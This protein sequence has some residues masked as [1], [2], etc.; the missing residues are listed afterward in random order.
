MDTSRPNTDSS[1][2]AYITLLEWMSKHGGHIHESVQIA[3]DERRG[4]H[5]QVKADCRDGLPSNTNVIKTPLAAT[6]SY[7]N[8]IEHRSAATEDEK[9]PVSFSAHGLHFPRSFV[10]AAGPDETAIFF[11]I[12]QYLRGS[13]GFWYPYICT[14]PQPGDLTTPLY[15]EG[16]DLR[17]LEGT[18]LAPAREQKESLL[19][20]KYQS[21]FEELRNSGFG[22]AEKYTW[23][24]YLWASTIFVSRAFSAKVLAG[25]IPH[26]ELPEENVSVL[27]PFI[28]VLNHRPLAK[29]EWRAGERDVLFVVLEH[30]AAGEEVANNYGPRNN[31][32]LMMNYGFCLQNNPCDYRT[33]SL[34]APPGSPL[35]DAKKAQLE[36]FPSREKDDHYYVFNI[37]YPLLAPDTSMEHSIFSPALLNAVSVLAANSRELETLEVSEHEI[38]LTQVYARTRPIL[39]ALGQVIIELITHIVRLKAS[40]DG[41]DNP[42]NLKQTHANIYRNSQIMLSQTALVIAAWTLNRARQHN[43]GSSWEETKQLLA[44]HMARVPAGLFPEEV[45]SR[46]QFRILERPSLVTNNGELFTPGDLSE[47]FAAGMQKPCKA[48]IEAATTAGWEGQLGP[49]PF[50]F[51][52]FLCLV[53]GIHRADTGASVL[54]PR[55]KTWVSFLLEKYESLPPSSEELLSLPDPE[56]E[57]LLTGLDEHIER[58][59]SDRKWVSLLSD[60]EAYAGDWRS[61]DW[62]LSPNSLRWAWMVV[63]EETVQIP[64]DPLGLLVAAE[65]GGSVQLATESYLYVAGEV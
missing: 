48:F 19:K 16:A 32:Q 7:F 50:V 46:I 14:L 40:A 52:I 33:L 47:L 61:V 62:W 29:V 23:E 55:L 17:W 44:A 27:L 51:P 4:V 49:S 35:Q 26:A 21:T 63:Q 37:F 64:E 25:V 36:M 58:C 15:Y 39:A 31:E 38:R 53:V 12:G 34:R 43:V 30:V 6:L 42:T 24:L 45:R 1:L 2:D 3:K 28:D 22:D 57:E 20:E 41:L 10:D 18:S 5:L 56:E 59:K 65:A 11:I 13:E 54:S 60:L 9:A 8:A